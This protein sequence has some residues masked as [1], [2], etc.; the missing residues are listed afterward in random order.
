MKFQQENL[1][2]PQE[3]QLFLYSDKDDGYG[4]YV[5][6]FEQDDEFLEEEELTCTPATFDMVKAD[7]LAEHLDNEAENGNYHSIVGAYAWL[8]KTITEASSELV[9]RRIMWEIIK[10]GGLEDFRR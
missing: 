10:I 6:D 5:T 4:R 1:F 2:M 8:A 7:W 9:A 3:P